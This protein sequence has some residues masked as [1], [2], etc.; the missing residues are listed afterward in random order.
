MATWIFLRGLSRERGHWGDFVDTFGAQFSADRVVLLDLPGNGR[1]YRQRSPLTVST[2]V[3][4]GRA[5]LA[6]RGM[7]PPYHLLAL[8]LGGMVAVAWAAAHPREVAAQVLINTSMRPFSPYYRRLRPGNYMKLAR[9]LL[10]GCS[11]DKLERTIF[12]IT[13]VRADDAVLR[14]WLVLRRLHPVSRL[15]TLRQLLAAARFR[16]SSTPPAAATLVLASAHD[17]LVSVRCSYAM[18]QAWNTPLC[19]HPWAGHDLPLDDGAWVAQQVHH[20]CVTN[21]S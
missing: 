20:W 18:A 16:A 9:L 17:Q 11:D 5:Q 7:A 10:P 14:D 19:V 15:N 2:M 6:Q 13:S 3:E 1:L 12:E 4:A 8:S 21:L